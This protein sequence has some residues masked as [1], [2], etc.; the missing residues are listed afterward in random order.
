MVFARRGR[1]IFAQ[2]EID[3]RSVGRNK[4]VTTWRVESTADFGGK[5]S[6]CHRLLQF[7]E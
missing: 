1:G 4:L 5:L 3:R 7:A 6:S 2:S